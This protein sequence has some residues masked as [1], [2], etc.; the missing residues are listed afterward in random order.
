MRVAQI[1]TCG[2]I[3]G[4]RLMRQTERAFCCI[5]DPVRVVKITGPGSCGPA[6]YFR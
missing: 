1:H 2:A 3:S 6:G 5:D 4:K